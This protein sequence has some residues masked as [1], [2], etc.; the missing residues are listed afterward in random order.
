[1]ASRASFLEQITIIYESDLLEKVCKPV[2]L[3]LEETNEVEYKKLFDGV[4]DLFIYTKEKNDD[5]FLKIY[6][7][8]LKEI[9]FCY[10]TNI[11]VNTHMKL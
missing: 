8:Q 2:T 10:R 1:M 3:L 9:A 5:Y 11:G 7:N 4:T 6:G